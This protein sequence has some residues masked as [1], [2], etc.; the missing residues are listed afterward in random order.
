M[1]VDDGVGKFLDKIE[2]YLEMSHF[3]A[4]V[5]WV[6]VNLSDLPDF[7][8]ILSIFIGSEQN[9]QRQNGRVVLT[10]FIVRLKY[11]CLGLVISGAQTKGGSLDVATILEGLLFVLSVLSV[12]LFCLYIV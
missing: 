5:G 7:P 11:L 1:F 2:K 9:I 10:P 12:G 3:L 8:I 6:I 4:F